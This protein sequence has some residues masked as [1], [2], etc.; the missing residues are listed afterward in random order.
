[1]KRSLSLTLAAVILSTALA[2]CAVGTESVSPNA[3]VRLTSSDAADAAAW[4]TERLGDRLTDSVVLGTDA[5]GYAL[6]LT[7]LEDDGFFIRSF[8]REDVLFAKT[9]DGLD[10]AVRKYAKAVES[11][12]PIT[13]ATYHEGARIKRIEIA[14]RDI[15]KYTIY[16]ENEAHMLAAAQTFSALIERACGASLPVVT[17]EAAEPY[18]AIRYAD[19]EALGLVG[20]RWAVDEGGLTIECSGDYKIE[21]ASV[22]T[23]RFLVNAFDWFGLD[24]GNEDL[25]AADLIEIAAGE[26][27]GET[28]YFDWVN[29]GALYG[30]AHI[31]NR[32]FALGPRKVADSGIEVNGFGYDL[33][34]SKNERGW[35]WI[36]KQPCWMDEYFY[37]VAKEDIIK[38]IEAKLD[39]G[40]VIGVDF[41][42]VDIAQADNNRWCDCKECTKVLRAEE[43]RS[44]VYLTWANRISAELEELYPGLTYEVFAYDDTKKPPKTIV[45]NDNLFVTFASDHACNSHPMNGLRCTTFDNWKLGFDSPTL[46]E[47]LKGW[48]ELTDNLGI[49]YYASSDG[50][51]TMSVT[52]TVRD[53]LQFL[54]DLG[55][56]EIYWENKGNTF[57]TNIVSQWLSYQMYWDVGM[58]KKRFDELYD[59]ILENLYG[60]AAAEVKHYITLSDM[61]YANGPCRNA[62]NGFAVTLPEEGAPFNRERLAEIFDLTF[63]LLEGAIA[64]ADTEE[65]E[66]R[67]TKLECSNIF[68][69]CLSAYEKALA[70]GDA[71]RMTALEARYALIDERLRAYGIDMTQ[72]IPDY[73]LKVYKTKL[74]SYFGN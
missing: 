12:A 68:M 55:V 17:G 53:D 7:A 40:M 58:S 25:P 52:H 8:G 61:S 14:G 19:D 5:D 21:S 60:G 30:G 2:S 42:A 48:S 33:S 72:G 71:E 74:S 27:G 6:D 15:S 9:T 35:A 65:Q 73:S 56:R 49:W 34:P 54:H 50:L 24:Y 26:S 62:W 46:A 38:Y 13:D 11:G 39:A 4:L 37:E 57:D 3:N 69:G 31:E 10:R 41:F 23:V 47:Y 64:L 16:A 63:E 22:A 29:P 32:R 18:I 44:G 70:E 59:R 51:A 43:A 66:T 28:P 36:D 67:I 20:Y 45:P 1:M